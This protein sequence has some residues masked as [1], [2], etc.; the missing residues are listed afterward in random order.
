MILSLSL[1]GCGSAV[2]ANKLAGKP[3]RPMISKQYEDNLMK[4][5]ALMGWDIVRQAQSHEV[6]WLGYAEKMENR[7]GY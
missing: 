5:G 6:D 3:D 4:A 2:T 1:T 7:A